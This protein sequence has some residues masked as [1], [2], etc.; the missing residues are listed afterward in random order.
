MV[1]SGYT[2]DRCIYF[3]QEN[4]TPQY[5]FSLQKMRSGDTVFTQ[6]ATRSAYRPETGVGVDLFGTISNTSRY[7]D[8][9]VLQKNNGSSSFYGGFDLR[10]VFCPS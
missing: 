6:I 1:K 10:L 4:S 9:Y 7:G 8:F 3:H 5:N 2:L